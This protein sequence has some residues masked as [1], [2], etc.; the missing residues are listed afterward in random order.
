MLN[1]FTIIEAKFMQSNNFAL[2]W[3]NNFEII[4]YF[5]IKIQQKPCQ[6]PTYSYIVN[7]R[8]NWGASYVA[9][10]EKYNWT[11]L[12]WDSTKQWFLIKNILVSI[13]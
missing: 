9:S 6:K 2:I 10:N 5:S 11:L 3:R 13:N 8:R 7:L 12:E 4:E 1:S